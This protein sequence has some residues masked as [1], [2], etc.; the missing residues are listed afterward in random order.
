MSARVVSYDEDGRK[1]LVTPPSSRAKGMVLVFHEVWGMTRHVRRACVDLAERGYLAAAQSYYSRENATFTPARIKDAM[2]VV[3]DLPLEDRYDPGRV[4]EALIAH[5]AGPQAGALL[6]RLYDRDFRDGLLRDAESLVEFL[7]RR[8]GAMAV[9]TLGFSM[10]GKLAL[11]LAASRRDS[12]VC[13]TFS[14]EP[15]S[16]E[17]LDRLNCPLLLLYGAD[18]SFM[19]EGLA[20]SVASALALRREFSLKVYS[21]AGHEFFDGY[22]RG[23]YNR[24]AALDAWDS[25]LRAIDGAFRRR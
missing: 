8:H 7:R 18:D 3:W 21:G 17:L 6:R 13:V 2:R 14:G 22:N 4:E 20:R 15:P 24:R 9:A 12:K 19:T 5:R 11:Q 1:A 16:P 23:A 25:S 10:G